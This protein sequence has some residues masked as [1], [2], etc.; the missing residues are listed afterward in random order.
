MAFR[1]WS[2]TRHPAQPGRLTPV[3]PSTVTA[4]VILILWFIFWRLVGRRAAS[5]T[6]RVHRRRKYTKYL[7][8]VKE[9]WEN[10]RPKP[11]DEKPAGKKSKE[12]K[13]EEEKAKEEKAKARRSKRARHLRDEIETLFGHISQPD[14]SRD[15]DLKDSLLKKYCNENPQSAGRGVLVAIKSFLYY[16]TVIWWIVILYTAGAKDKER[17]GH[18]SE[19]ESRRTN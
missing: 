3:F 11:I 7:D 10:D 4:F 5:Y 15:R 13:A 19:D 9:Q 2:F 14:I 6:W 17:L 18:T 16:A 12:K 8:K 1:E